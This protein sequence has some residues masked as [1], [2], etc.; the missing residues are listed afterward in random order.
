MDDLARQYLLVALGVGRLQDGIVDSYYGPVEVAAEA[1]L[2]A[3]SAAELVAD[4]ARVREL[5]AAD[6]DPQRALW[7][8]RQLLALETLARRLDGEEMA[9]IDEVERCFD[10]RPAATPDEIYSRA[11]RTLDALLEPGPSLSDRIESRGRRLTVPADRLHE[12]FEWLVGEAR[13]DSDRHFPAPA[14]EALTVSLVTDQPWSAY[15]WYDGNLRSRIEVNTDLPA[16][17]PSLIGLATHEAFPGHHLEH[18]SKE[19]RLAR[20]LGRSEA[21]AMLINTP[22]ALV[23]EGLAE[24]GRRYVMDAERWQEL[25]AGICARAGIELEADEPARQWQIGD[26]L[27]DLGAVAA[28]AAL[29]L[30]EEGRPRDEVVGFLRDAGL[31]T[32]ERAGKSLS[33]I[34]HPLWRTYVF[35][36]SGGEALLA[37]WCAA[38]G[39][40]AAQRARFGRLLTEQLTPSG[41]AAEIVV[42]T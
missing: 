22:E 27:N 39:D 4:A 32:T 3:A 12:I 13:R 2:R 16:R 17:A 14:G 15:N 28:D 11:H 35:C 42:R 25:F 36:Y 31:Q 5:A 26:T 41:M 29:L 23:S 18:A 6:A 33:F 7:L 38:A 20:E 8:D 34:S 9:Y 21:S 30:H 40:V 19:Q 37:A 10:A 24:L 1:E